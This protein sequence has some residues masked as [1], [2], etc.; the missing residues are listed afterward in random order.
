M[1]NHYIRK[2]IINAP[3]KFDNT[4]YYQVTFSYAKTI[5]K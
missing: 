4:D 3:V 5:S 1:E 2:T